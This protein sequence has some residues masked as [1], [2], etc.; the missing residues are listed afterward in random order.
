MS[1]DHLLPVLI[2][3]LLLAVVAGQEEERSEPL[4]THENRL[5]F[6]PAVAHSLNEAIQEEG[7]GARGDAHQNQGTG[8]DNTKRGR[9]G[10]KKEKELENYFSKKP[11]E[12]AESGV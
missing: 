8:N 12:A 4:T 6:P 1:F 5:H 3:P 2:V 11:R 10:P 7:G 9:G